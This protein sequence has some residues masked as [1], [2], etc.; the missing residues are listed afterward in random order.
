MQHRWSVTLSLLGLWFV[1]LLVTILLHWKTASFLMPI[2]LIILLL[3]ISFC[4]VFA[5]L[6]ANKN[7]NSVTDIPNGD[8]QNHEQLKQL[9]SPPKDPPPHP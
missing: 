7:N 3:Y 5:L 2:I 4:L 9:N 8:T 1:L 6:N